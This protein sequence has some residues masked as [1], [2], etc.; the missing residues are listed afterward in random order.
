MK[1]EM[2]YAKLAVAFLCI[3]WGTT[4]IAIKIGIQDV[5]PYLFAA[6]RQAVAGA[7]MVAICMLMKRGRLPGRKAILEQALPGLLLITCGQGFLNWALLYVPSGLAALIASMIPMYAV[8]F[9]L[10]M[11][12][13]D[14]VNASIWLGLGMGAAGMMLIFQE[15]VEQLLEPHYLIGVLLTFLGAFCWAGGSYLVQSN[16][17]SIEPLYKAGFQL[18]FGSA[19]LFVFAFFTSDY[20][21][22]VGFTWSSALALLYLIGPGS[23]AGYLA[24]LYAIKRLP[25]AEVAVYSYV[26]PIIT[27]SLGWLIFHE[28]LG[29]LIGIGFL[30]TLAGVFLVS[31][32]YQQLRSTPSEK[33]ETYR[34]KIVAG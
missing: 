29:I 19:G 17:S 8:I 31:R 7:I 1:K 13:S 6:L 2:L 18:L 5:P 14:K 25:V 20:E 16:K 21:H 11:P 3:L 30:I 27:L 10:F 12:S 32:G 22:F 15:N 24:Y 9:G 4:Y 33:K 28:P 34:K 23:I 26:N